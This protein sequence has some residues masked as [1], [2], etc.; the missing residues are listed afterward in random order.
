MLEAL[1]KLW[2]ALNID[3]S[4]TDEDI[5]LD[6]DGFR[7]ALVFD[8]NHH[9]LFISPED[10]NLAIKA[11]LIDAA[12]EQEGK[13]VYQENWQWPIDIW[14]LRNLIAIAHQEPNPDIALM[15]IVLSHGFQEY[16][17]ENEDE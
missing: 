1:K 4:L 11:E 17:P 6:E 9:P 13:L 16:N 7:K 2:A 10:I 5:E 14:G 15:S 8:T 12:D 3:L